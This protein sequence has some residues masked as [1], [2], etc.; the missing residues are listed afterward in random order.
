VR[1]GEMVDIPGASWEALREALAEGRGVILATGHYGNWE[2]AA[3]AIAARGVPIEAIV[4]RQ[5]NPLVDARIAATR[6]ALGVETIEMGQA[7]REVPRALLSGATVGIVADQDA[8]RSGVW[9]PFFGLPASTH[10][11]PALFSLRLGSP[12]FAAVARRLPDGRYLLDGE[13]I[14]TTPRGPIEDDVAR[15]TAAVAAH[16]EREIRKDPAQYFWLHKR[17]KTRPAEEHLPR[18]AG[19]RGNGGRGEPRP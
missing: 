19:T 3:A 12:L 11:G 4:K 7:R 18:E 8:R 14:D 13:R 10:R 9:V 5:S 2:M 1:V 6:R 15:I 16:L 17:W